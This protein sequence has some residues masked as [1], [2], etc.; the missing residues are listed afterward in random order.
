MFKCLEKGADLVEEVNVNYFLS[1]FVVFL[2]G[3]GHGGKFSHS[4]Y[5]MCI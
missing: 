3:S 5:N 2:T 4:T 1:F